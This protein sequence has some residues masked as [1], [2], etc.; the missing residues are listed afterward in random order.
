MVHPY[1]IHALS[2]AITEARAIYAATDTIA[3]LARLNELQQT[4]ARLLTTNAGDTRRE[5]GRV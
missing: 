4:R 1:R 3:A 2:Q 5:G